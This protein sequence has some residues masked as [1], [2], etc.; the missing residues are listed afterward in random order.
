MS[1]ACSCHHSSELPPFWSNLE[2]PESWSSPL[3]F[4][5]PKSFF[6]LMAFAGA[7]FGPLLGLVFQLCRVFPDGLTPVSKTSWLAIL[8]ALHHN[9]PC[10]G[11]CLPLDWFQCPAGHLDAGQVLSVLRTLTERQVKRDTA[12]TALE[13]VWRFIEQ[14]ESQLNVVGRP[15]QVQSFRQEGWLVS[16]FPHRIPVSLPSFPTCS[17][18]GPSHPASHRAEWGILKS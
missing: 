17:P 13:K 12:E 10:F 18:Q 15:S 11:L 8:N 5:T 16:G 6:C 14:S 3:C 9:H 2:D 4:S 7:A 1:S